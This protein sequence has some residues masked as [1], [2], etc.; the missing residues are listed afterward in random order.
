MAHEAKVET[1]IQTVIAFQRGKELANARNMLHKMAMFTT[2]IQ[3]LPGVYL[4]I[5]QGA[6]VYVGQ[7]GNVCG[8]LSGHKTRLYDS[9]RML[10]VYGD[11]ERSKLE[12]DLIAALQPEDNRQLKKLRKAAVFAGEQR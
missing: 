9:I 12:A 8:R 7:S 3:P 1:N 10:V 5:D 6:V 2:E 11:A 4:L